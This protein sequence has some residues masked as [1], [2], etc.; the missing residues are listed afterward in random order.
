MNIMGRGWK[1]RICCAVMRVARVIGGR[2][3]SVPLVRELRVGIEHKRRLTT[4]CFSIL[5]RSLLGF[6]LWVVGAGGVHIDG[7]EGVGRLQLVL[8]IAIGIAIRLLT[9]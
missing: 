7:L 1:G 9:I 3:D 2:G 4:P 8:F 6:F 5:N